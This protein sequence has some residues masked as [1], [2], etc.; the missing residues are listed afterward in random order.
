MLSLYG[1]AFFNSFTL[2][3]VL[4][5]LYYSGRGYGDSFSSVSLV[6]I[7]LNKSLLSFQIVFHLISTLLYLINDPREYCGYF[8]ILYPSVRS[9]HN[10]TYT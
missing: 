2:D 6:L 5:F 1:F 10:Q 9:F 4:N 8:A 7:R 3:N